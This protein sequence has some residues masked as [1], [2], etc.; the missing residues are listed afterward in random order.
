MDSL[1]Y[2][3]LSLALHT[4]TRATSLDSLKFHPLLLSFSSNTH[5][6]QNL[7]KPIYSLSHFLS[8]THIQTETIKLSRSFLIHPFDLSNS[9]SFYPQHIFFHRFMTYWGI[10]RWIPLIL[11][12]RCNKTSV[13]Y[14]RALKLPSWTVHHVYVLF[15][16]SRVDLQ[17]ANECTHVNCEQWLCMCVETVCAS[18]LIHLCVS[19]ILMSMCCDSSMGLKNSSNFP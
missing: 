16:F 1:L 8:H 10:V 19:S 7:Y 3:P 9:L 5:H 14:L 6:L 2:L 13:I 17:C 12:W 4:H 18:L 15:L 11:H